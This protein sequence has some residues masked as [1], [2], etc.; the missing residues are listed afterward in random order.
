MAHFDSSREA[1]SRAVS[2][3]PVHGPVIRRLFLISPEFR[4]LCGDYALAQNTMLRLQEQSKPA[5]DLVIA[6]YAV[7]IP[8]LEAEIEHALH[9]PR[10]ELLKQR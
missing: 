10:Q 3:F 5:N 4:D 7:L 9:D 1:L 8:A 2:R 6:D